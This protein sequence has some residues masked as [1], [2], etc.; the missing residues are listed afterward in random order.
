MYNF[1]TIGKKVK[2]LREKNQMSQVDLAFLI[3]VSPA[4]IG[5]LEKGFKS[6]S[7]ETLIKLA[8]VFKV[9]TDVLLSDCLEDNRSIGNKELCNLLDGC[10]AYESRI[11]VESAKKLKEVL[12]DSRFINKSSD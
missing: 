6:M 9:T 11:I 8:N 3:D 5:Y 7:L 2:K 4:Y 1:L 12:I 10:S